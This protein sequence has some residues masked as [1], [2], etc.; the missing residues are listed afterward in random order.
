MYGGDWVAGGLERLAYAGARS[1]STTTA[2][3]ER[4]DE[5]GHGGVQQLCTDRA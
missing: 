5:F 3:R 1:V 4:A 2:E